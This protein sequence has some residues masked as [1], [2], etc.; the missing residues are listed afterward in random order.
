MNKNLEQK[1]E[2]TIKFLYTQEIPLDDKNTFELISRADTD[3]IF[4]LDSNWDK[5]DLQQIKP[6]SI[7]ELT[8]A[9]TL[10]HSYNLNSYIYTYLKRQAVVPF[11]CPEFSPIPEVQKI[12]E[13]THGI[14]LYNEQVTAIFKVFASLSEED[15][16]KYQ[17]AIN[18]IQKEIES[19]CTSSKAFFHKRALVCYKLAYLKA[20]HPNVFMQY[21]EMVEKN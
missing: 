19:H 5:Y 13:E 9:L 4:M 10:S 18:L 8:A 20:N 1:I 11:T 17:I 12:L 14:I 16:K 6:Q 21:L 15:Q 2:E 3:G 7:E